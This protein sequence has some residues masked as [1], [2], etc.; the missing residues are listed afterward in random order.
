MLEYLL[1][2]E[3]KFDDPRQRLAELMGITRSEL[4][5]LLGKVYLENSRRPSFELLFKL[6]FYF[7]NAPLADRIMLFT[8]ADYNL[9]L[10]QNQHILELLNQMENWKNYN[11]SKQYEL[12]CKRI[13]FQKY[14]H[15]REN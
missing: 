13:N 2:Q 1:K 6:C 3:G 9:L 10:P 4:Y 15:T 11:V 14:S 12:L 7:E 8:Y 5:N